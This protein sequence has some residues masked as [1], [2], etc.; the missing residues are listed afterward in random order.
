MRKRG[1]LS[2]CVRRR[3]RC[4]KCCRCVKRRRLAKR[5][6]RGGTRAGRGWRNRRRGAAAVRVRPVSVF[7]AVTR[8]FHVLPA[9]LD[10]RVEVAIPATAFVNDDGAPSTELPI[11]GEQGY[12]NLY[13]NGVMQQGKLYRVAPDAVSIAATGQTLKAGTAIVL[14]TVRFRAEAG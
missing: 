5:T 14:E 3:K 10:F 9:D 6:K 12:Y 11:A 4:C 13:V 1:K 8:H 2:R 7:P